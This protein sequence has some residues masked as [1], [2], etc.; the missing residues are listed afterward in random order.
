MQLVAPKVS[1]ASRN[2]TNTFLS[3]RRLA[4]RV[5]PIVIS[6]MRPSGTLA[7]MTPIAKMKLRMTGYPIA[8]PSPKRRPPMKREKN[9][10]LT[11][12]RLISAWRGVNYSCYPAEAARLAICPM[13]VLSPVAKTS[14]RPV[15]SLFRVEKNAIFLVSRGLSLVHSGILS[16]SSVSPVRE[17]LSTFISTEFT[18]L[19]SAGIFLPSYIRTKSPTTSWSASRTF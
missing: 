12:K 13:K 4:V 2:F 5:S 1:T 17:E 16:K 7:V 3:A 8:K 10:S 6:T 9:V 19:R 15:P 14:P 11:I 18:I